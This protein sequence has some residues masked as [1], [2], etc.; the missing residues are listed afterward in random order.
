MHTVNFADSM[1]LVRAM[2]SWYGNRLSQIILK[3]DKNGKNTNCK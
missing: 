2:L 1:I 3:L